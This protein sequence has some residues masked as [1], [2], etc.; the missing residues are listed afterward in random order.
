M[1]SE[2]SQNNSTYYANSDAVASEN[3]RLKLIIAHKDELLAQKEKEIAHLSK[4]INM[5]EK[6]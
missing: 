3:E 5:L 2:N 6:A 1:F 4:I